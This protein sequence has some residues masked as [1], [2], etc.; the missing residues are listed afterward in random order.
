PY[1][2]YNPPPQALRKQ[3]SQINRTPPPQQLIISS[4]TRITNPNNPASEDKKAAKKPKNQNKYRNQRQQNPQEEKNGKPEKPK[5]HIRTSWTQTA[6][7]FGR[8]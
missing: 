7:T 4:L 5:N 1:K 8:R 3:F 6:L 2:R